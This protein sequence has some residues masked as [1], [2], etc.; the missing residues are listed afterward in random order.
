MN[1]IRRQLRYLY[2]DITLESEGQEQQSSQLNDEDQESMEREAAQRHNFCHALRL[3]VNVVHTT[4]MNDTMRSN[5]CLV[6]SRGLRQPFSKCRENK[7]HFLHCGSFGTFGSTEAH[8]LVLKGGDNLKWS[9]FLIS[10]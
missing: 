5:I 4:Y 6:H 10:F 2:V 3:R 8:E 7:Y 1:Q 9:I